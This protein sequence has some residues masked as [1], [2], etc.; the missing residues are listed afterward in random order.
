MPDGLMGYTENPQRRPEPGDRP[1]AYKVRGIVLRSVA[2]GE[3]DRLLTVLTPD[4]GK[5]SIVVKG[6]RRS[7][8]K[9]AGH[10]DVLNHCRLS[11]ALGHR[12]D[13]VT[14]AEVIYPF[15]YIKNTLEALS[16]ALYLAESI[17][18]LLPEASSSPEAYSLALAALHALESQFQPEI[19]SAFTKLKLL[20]VAGYKPELGRCLICFRPLEAGEHRYA[21]RLGGTVDGAC[22]VS[23]GRVLPLSVDALKVLRYFAN[24]GIDKLRAMKLTPS[25]M[26]EITGLLEQSHFEITERRVSSAGFVQDVRRLPG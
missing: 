9:L 6:A 7:K 5:M 12:W 24:S 8:S 23:A 26:D 10:V 11:L 1:R 16:V 14:G 18:S 4:L 20:E 13:V 3:A 19:V 25:L 15:P 21:P 22:P 2:N 17:D